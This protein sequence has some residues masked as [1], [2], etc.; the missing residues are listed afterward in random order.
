MG[1]MELG[2][3]DVVVLCPRGLEEDLFAHYKSLVFTSKLVQIQPN[4][5]HT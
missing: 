4:M 5:W 2:S 1:S 3:G